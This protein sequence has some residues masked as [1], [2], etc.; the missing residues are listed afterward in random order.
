MS[1]IRLFTITIVKNYDTFLLVYYY[2]LKFNYEFG[3][4]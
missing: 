3:K 4:Y 1:K 2:T